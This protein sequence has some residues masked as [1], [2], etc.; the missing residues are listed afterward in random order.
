[1][2]PLSLPSIRNCVEQ[3]LIVIIQLNTP[4]SPQHRQGHISQ[5]MKN[6]DRNIYQLYC[7]INNNIKCNIPGDGTL[8]VLAYFSSAAVPGSSPTAAFHSN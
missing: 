7:C 3:H 1:M 5:H 8:K 4:T 6:S 2:S